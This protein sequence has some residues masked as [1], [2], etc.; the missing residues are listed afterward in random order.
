MSTRLIGVV[1]LAAIG[2]ALLLYAAHISAR[3]TSALD[4]ADQELV[5]ILSQAGF[6][7]RVESTLEQRLG[8]RLDPRLADLGR[9]LWFDT[10]TG[11]NND[12]TCAGCHSPSAGFGDTQAIAIG[13]ENNGV[14]GPHRVGPR[15]MRRTPMVI[16]SAFFPNLMW[17]SRFAALSGD[18]FDNHVG[19]LFPAPEGLALSAEPHLLVAQAF[20]PPTERTE[21]A[22]FAFPG[23]N[24]AL[25]TEVLRRI[26]DVPAYRQRFGAIFPEVR[27]GTPITYAMFA[28][29]IAE[30]EF[31]LTFA[32][33]PIDRFARGALTGD[34]QQGAL[35]FFGQAGCV[36]CHA[37][38]GGASEMF[39]DFQD[40]AIG[41]PQLV[42]RVTNNQFDG[43]GANE[44][45]GREEITG[46]PADRYKFRT[47]PLRN[48]ALQPTFMH[49]GAF[50]S[51]EDAVRHH[52]DVA[53]SARRYSPAAQGLPADLA[54]PLGPLDPVLA[55]VDPRLATPQHL[56]AEQVCQLVAF[57]GDGLL[58]PQARPGRLRALVPQAVP[59]GRPVLRFEF[60][61]D[62]APR[63]GHDRCAPRSR[64][65]GRDVRYGLAQVLLVA[66]PTLGGVQAGRARRRRRPGAA[67]V[68]RGSGARGVYRVAYPQQDVA[69]GL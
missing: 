69:P 55:R 3:E 23:D 46:D 13:I 50:T 53:G 5:T 27:G 16:N 36:G 6:T 64:A 7:G 10:I 61:A 47:S 26:N 56:T 1:A 67:M 24:D 62:R 21:V 59:S 35:L 20:I 12:N 30:F 68:A 40:H 45:F 22:G 11:L 17:N 15:N 8:R 37:V 65:E 49:N 42:P 48:V 34:E 63:H 57:V 52:L 66:G 29:A 60:P 4:P 32:D 19:F 39:S 33:A 25:R 9:L 54:G 41:V 51:L 43:P 38:A 58:D 18:P 2:A 44:D 31:T 28:R 14:V